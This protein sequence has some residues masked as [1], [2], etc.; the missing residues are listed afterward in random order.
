MN[1]AVV[2][3]HPDDEAYGP[4]GTIN[5]LVRLGHTVSVYA[6]CNGARPGAE[7]VSTTRQEVFF[8][9][10]ISVGATPH[11]YDTAD[12]DLELNAT[13]HL[14]TDVF[15]R[16]RPEI[17]YTHNISDINHDH[18]IVAEAVLIAARPKP[19]SS[20]DE[21]YFFEIPSSTDWGFHKIGA[22][23]QPNVYKEI[24]THDMDIKKHAM[25]SY[26]TEVYDFPDARSV[27]A[28][29]ALAKY[30]GYQAGLQYAEAFQLVFARNRK[31]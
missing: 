26:L 7:H 13:A 8:Q 29:V 6:M 31:T 30:R 1:V 3:A 14:L 17:V 5:A 25:G 15:A 10:C 2:V 23:F 20:V 4:F 18:Q 28:M 24:D 21:L 11:I 9:N 19:A 16:T 12:L 22:E 27:D